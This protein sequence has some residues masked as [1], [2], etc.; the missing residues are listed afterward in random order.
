MCQK[1]VNVDGVILHSAV[2]RYT[3]QESVNVDGVILHSAVCRYTY[4][5]SVN[6]A[7]CNIAPCCVQVYVSGIR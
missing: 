1:S 3:Y 7:R 4:Q 6:V 2:C 5:E